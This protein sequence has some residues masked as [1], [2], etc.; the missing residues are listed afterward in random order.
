MPDG[1]VIDEYGNKAWYQHGFLHRK[2]GPAIIYPDGSQLWFFEGD[3]HRSDGPAII[4]PDGTEKWFCYG[5]PTN[6]SRTPPVLT[7]NRS[8]DM[9]RTIKKLICTLTKT[10]VSVD[11]DFIPK[12]TPVQVLQW[13]AEKENFVDV[14]TEVHMYADHVNDDAFED[15]QGAIGRGLYIS[16]S[17]EDLEYMT[18]VNSTN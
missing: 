11:G 18:S 5:K 12:G 17:I 6:I 13:C 3:L 2:D 4:Y 1:L 14:R 8:D 16:V 7:P 9:G 10:H 15:Y